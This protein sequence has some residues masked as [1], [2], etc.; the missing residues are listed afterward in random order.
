VKDNLF[1]YKEVSAGWS[2]DVV[3]FRELGHNTNIESAG[4]TGSSAPYPVKYIEFTISGTNL[5]ANKKK[6]EDFLKKITLQFHI[7][8]EK[9]ISFPNL[10]D[11]KMKLDW[12]VYELP[13]N[14]YIGVGK[15]FNARLSIKEA[16]PLEMTLKV[17]LVY[18]EV[19]EE[20]NKS[21]NCK[22]SILMISG[23]QCGGI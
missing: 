1:H 17:L 6:V 3:F 11:S 12:L 16:F 7:E 23:C 5:K 20:T 13:I 21:C 15:S 19:K 4:L 10:Y 18:G 14:K 2:T 22:I 9:I 8:G